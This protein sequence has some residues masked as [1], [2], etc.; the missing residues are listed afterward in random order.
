MTLAVGTRLGPYEI[1]GPLGAG[2][3]GEVFRARDTRLNREVAVKVLPEEFAKDPDRLSRFE[4]EAQSVAALSHPNILSLHDF[5]REGDIPYAVMEY[6]EGATLR[7]RLRDGPL[8]VRKAV[9]IAVEVAQGLGAAH[10]KGIV[11]R[12]LK[13]EN[14]FVT[15]DGRVK[16]LDFGL[17]KVQLARPGS[18]DVTRSLEKDESTAAGAILGTVGYLSPEQAR[19]EAADGRSDIF[20]LGCVL[21]EMLTGKRP[22]HRDSVVESLHAVLKEDPPPFSAAKSPLPPDVERITLR[23][24]EKAPG[25]RFQSARDL[26]FALGALSSK[27]VHSGLSHSAIRGASP[28]LA[29]GRGWVLRG[30]TALALLL[31]ITG[32][33]GWR[34]L[35][36][37][38]PE[39]ASGSPCLAIDLPED[40]WYESFSVSP[41]GAAVVFTA[42]HQKPGEPLPKP[43]LYVRRFD[44]FEPKL[45]P[46]T[47]RATGVMFSPD[48]RWVAFMAPDPQSELKWMLKKMPL[49]GSAAPITIGEGSESWEGGAWLKAGDFLFLDPGGWKVVLMGASGGPPQRI[50]IERGAFKGKLI[51]MACTSR[52]ER[53]LLVIASAPTA[54]ANQQDVGFI[55]LGER[56]FRVL[57][58]NAGNATLSPE[59]DLYFSRR[60]ELLAARFD[61]S[62]GILLSQP[63]TV[64]E[65]LR[66]WSA[67]GY[68]PFDMDGLG[69]LYFIRGGVGGMRR[70]IEV[71][72]PEGKGTDWSPERRAFS[73]D[74]VVSPHAKFL[75]TVLINADGFGE[76]WV[77]DLDHPSFRRLVSVPAA[78]TIYPVLSPDEAHLAFFR[79]GDEKAGIYLVALDGSTPPRL[80]LEAR[81]VGKELIS[82]EAFTPDGGALV[83]YVAGSEGEEGSLS[84]LPLGRDLSPS[85]PLHPLFSTLRS[86]T[87]PTF[88]PDGK[89]LAFYSY[90]SQKPLL[91]VAPWQP[92]KPVGV[93][94]ELPQGS[95]SADSRIFWAPDGKS[96]YVV[97]ESRRVIQ[98]AIKEGSM[99][100]LGEPVPV[101]L[102]NVQE[103]MSTY[104]GM[105][106]LPDGR[107]IAVRRGQDEEARLSRLDVVLGASATFRSQFLR[108]NH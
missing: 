107:F 108:G 91:C 67:S 101:G 42:F 39:G 1:L 99:P 90:D 88:S 89:R 80:L 8:P 103:I 5:G 92:G 3:M 62:K 50:P 64:T 44:N 32:L 86:A 60:N 68:G 28:R 37:H 59:G 100:S 77:S 25:E 41:D 94:S 105:D 4:R 2:G 11:H 102:L 16:I 20:S 27:S 9:D 13:P 78:S 46:G 6:L 31:A 71:L 43:M 74:M 49:D 61:A 12:D 53:G 66:T 30:A 29:L 7:D 104:F 45:L 14:L 75:A 17:A 23:C 73:A 48:G 19:G 58:E 79:T 57:V 95:V 21:Y 81:Q 69:T 55:D 97:D 93:Y 65:G 84:L 83:V 34:L 18:S 70:S 40:F 51:S 10:E 47:E 96:L 98:V 15:K 33:L 56:T 52:D 35:A 24:L 54:R 72:S 26:A 82:P 87:W 36:G 85:G 63:V 22:F 38:R 76:L 106:I